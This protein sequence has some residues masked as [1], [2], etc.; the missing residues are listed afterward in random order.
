MPLTINYTGE[1]F[2]IDDDAFKAWIDQSKPAVPHRHD[3]EAGASAATLFYD[4]CA[5][6]VIVTP[7]GLTADCYGD[8][9]AEASGVTLVI[10]PSASAARVGI[11]NGW[12][13]VDEFAVSDENGKTD[14]STAPEAVRDAIEYF[15][16]GLNSALGVSATT[17]E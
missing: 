5:A 3:P 10:Y 4:A 12:H 1:P 15:T 9:D 17:E 16:H 7:D 6:G 14:S 8:D 11:T 2:R 13:N